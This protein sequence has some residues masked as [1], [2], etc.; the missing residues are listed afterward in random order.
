MPESVLKPP[1]KFIPQSKL[2]GSFLRTT[3]QTIVLFLLEI[4]RPIC[5]PASKRNFRRIGF[6]N[7][8][9]I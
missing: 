8:K 2:L 9:L 5:G 6:N 3:K 1:P 4:A 7:G